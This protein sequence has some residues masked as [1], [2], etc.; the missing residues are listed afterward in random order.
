MSSNSTSNDDTYN[1]DAEE[2]VWGWTLTEEGISA[3]FVSFLSLLA[4]TLFLSKY[5]Y[6]FPRIGSILPE[7]G[8]TV[9]IG[10][11]AGFFINAQFSRVNEQDQQTNDDDF[12]RPVATTLLG[13]SST[14]FFVALLPPIIF[15][16]GYHLKRDLF[17]RHLTAITLYACAGTIVS[18]IVVG[19]LLYALVSLGLTGDFNPSFA[20]LLTFGALISATDPVS[21]LA[22]FQQKK[23]NPQLFYLVFGESVLNDAVGIVLFNALSKFVGVHDTITQFALG[24]SV[25]FVD[26]TILFLGSLALGVASGVVLALFFKVA[27][28]RLEKTRLLE[29]SLYVLVVYFPFFIAE[30]SGFSGIVTILFTGIT[31]QRYAVYNISPSTA[32]EA[33]VIFRLLSHLA[34]IAIFLNLG[35]SFYDD[36]G[37]KLKYMFVLWAVIACLIARACNV[38]PITFFY[39]KAIVYLAEK[40]FSEVEHNSLNASSGNAMN[41]PNGTEGS[42]TTGI[43]YVKKN[44]ANMLWFSGLRGAVAYACAK[45]FPDDNGNSQAFI[46][47]TMAIVLLSIFLLGSTT[48]LALSALDIEVDV[49]EDQYM[50][51]H[52]EKSFSCFQRFENKYIL[53]LLLRDLRE[54]ADNNQKRVLL[55]E[56]FSDLDLSD[57]VPVRPT[58]DGDVELREQSDSLTRNEQPDSLSNFEQFNG[59]PSAKMHRG[60]YSMYDFGA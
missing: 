27:N 4:F 41:M 58:H 1:Q 59:S 20:E 5:L 22:V 52:L 17:V 16:S 12:N 21:T 48:S 60:E 44:T 15:N 42:H 35:L 45:T 26:F 11:I 56:F 49:D 53:P 34:E 50:Q 28:F 32:L 54:D 30:M 31:T 3:Y 29:L 13:F 9:I 24:A 40:K 6:Q 19:L 46:S 37:E 38:Y 10:I 33:D 14:V 51:E 18:T 25:F 43:Y 39:N 2:L 57:F 55:S 47:I 7:A 8:L 36:H 23:V